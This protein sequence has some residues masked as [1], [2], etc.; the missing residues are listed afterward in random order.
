MQ[1]TTVCHR[2]AI[3]HKTLLSQWQRDRHH[4]KI[5]SKAVSKAVVILPG[6]WC[7]QPSARDLHAHALCPIL[8][9]ETLFSGTVVS[10]YLNWLSQNSS[11]WLPYSSGAGKSHNE[12]LAQ[13]P[14]VAG[15]VPLG[16]LGRILFPKLP[17]S[18]GCPHPWTYLI[19][20]LPSEQCGFP[21]TTRMKA[22]L[23]CRGR[24]ISESLNGQ[25]GFFWTI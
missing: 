15:L 1:R 22:F 13:S 25:A 5:T 9:Y 6:A 10:R 17:V 3:L 18:W 21:L 2:K 14:G 24:L 7:F 23:P 19:L 12:Q 20:C 4:G 16:P 8:A 11:T